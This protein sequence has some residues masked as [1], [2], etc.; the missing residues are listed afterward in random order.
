MKLDNG[1]FLQI[2]ETSLPGYKPKT[3]Q[4]ILAEYAILQELGNKAGGKADV[5]LYDAYN[6]L[7]KGIFTL[8]PET[9]DSIG[10]DPVGV[11]NMWIGGDYLNLN[12]FYEGYNRTHFITLA[13]EGREPREGEVHLEIRHNAH[14]DFPQYIHTGM[15]CFDL[16]SL[17]PLTSGDY[18]NLVILYKGYDHKE[19]TYELKYQFGENTNTN[20]D[21]D[22]ST[23][24]EVRNVDV[25]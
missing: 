5:K 3:G 18:L 15:A 22:K 24:D 10:H 2:T 23:A 4:R 14:K 8:T 17:Q 13:K 19:H 16:R 25:K 1:K 11:R 6:L 7:T 20:P 12:F 21:F 9:Q